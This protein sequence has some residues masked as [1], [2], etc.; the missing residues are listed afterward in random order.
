MSSRPTTPIILAILSVAF[1]SSCGDNSQSPGLEYM[2]DMYRG[3]AIEAYVDY[4]QDPYHYGEDLAAE[5]RERPSA[6]VP[7]AGTIPFSLDTSK[8]S[9]N[10][11]YPYPNTNEGYEA[12]G[13]ELT[14][15]IPMTE[16]TVT[17]GKVI[18]EKF[19]DHCHGAKGLGDGPVVDPAKGGHPPPT[20][21]NGPLRE[22]P[23]GKMFHTVTYGKGM[24][25]PHAPLL[26]QEERWLVVQ[27][28]KYLQADETLPGG[29][30][31]GGGGTAP[32]EGDRAGAEGTVNEAGA[33]GATAG[34]DTTA[35]NAQEGGM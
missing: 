11:P 17:R 1:V 9:F 24:M 20:A 32:P 6:R 22:L 30:K 15:P 7:A 34:T 25:G 29:G 14:S 26:D 5:Q 23:E 18:Y 8:A 13:A 21:F 2:P 19:C 33:T 28:V 4:G 31:L 16:A 35:T 3:P 27:Y 12:A 10:M